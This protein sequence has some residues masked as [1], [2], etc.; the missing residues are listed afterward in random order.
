M[1]GWPMR[2]GSTS[3]IAPTMGHSL[4]RLIVSRT[5]AMLRVNSS[6]NE[7]MKLTTFLHLRIFF[8]GFL[9]IALCLTVSGCDKNRH[10]VGA[11]DTSDTEGE[12]EGES[13][14]GDPSKG[15]QGDDITTERDGCRQLACEPGGLECAKGEKCTPWQCGESC[16]VNS[17]RCAKITGSIEEGLPCVR[18][19]ETQTDDCA[20][21]LFC[22]VDAGPSGAGGPGH[23][24]QLCIPQVGGH[25][26]GE[27][28]GFTGNHC[29]AFNGG[30]NP[31][32]LE[33]CDPFAINCPSNPEKRCFFDLDHFLCGFQTWNSAEGEACFDF[34]ECNL[35]LVCVPPRS[36]WW[37][38]SEGSCA[39]VCDLSASDPDTNCRQESTCMR[40]L[41]EA[42]DDIAH[43]GICTSESLP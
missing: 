10:A 9:G 33:T 27:A 8:T 42:A 19:L 12:S 3:I 39:R 6:H 2:G 29:F 5:I 36:G 1:R 14:G 32:C 34:A 40:L 30:A 22:Q 11:G 41:D 31:L 15:S 35:G 7:P 26:N 37:S 18:D 38:G 17:T 24:Q 16:C 21:S 28:L 43:V 20:A 23:C 13:K 4:E 25:G